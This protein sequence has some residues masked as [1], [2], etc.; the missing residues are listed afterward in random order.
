[1]ISEIIFFY[2]RVTLLKTLRLCC[3]KIL[4]HLKKLVQP[5]SLP[6]MEPI[7]IRKITGFRWNLENS[8]HLHK[9]SIEIRSQKHLVFLY[10]DLFF[11]KTSKARIKGS[12]ETGSS[13]GALFSN[14]KYDVVA[15]TSITHDCCFSRQLQSILESSN[16]DKIS[17]VLL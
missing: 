10:S 17:L 6:L 9:L 12:A 3:V 8:D 13:V 16:Q 5:L 1:M 15:P 11:K 14:L 4:R 7:H 2:Q